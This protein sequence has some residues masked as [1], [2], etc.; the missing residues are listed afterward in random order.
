[1]RTLKVL[2]YGDIDLNFMDGSAV[3]L[4]SMA[5]MLTQNQNI[6]VDL[7]IKAP[8][9]QK[10]LIEALDDIPN[11]HLIEPYAKK[12]HYPFIP[13]N[14]LDVESAVKIMDRLNQENAYHLIIIRGQNLTLELSK[15]SSLKEK[16]VPYITDF[17]HSENES[18]KEERK[19]LKYIYDEF[20]HIFLQ[21]KETKGAFQKLLKVDGQKV[22][23][24]SPMVPNVE[25]T[26][27]FQNKNNQLVYA[28]KFHEDWHTEE[29]IQAAINMEERQKDINF[30][31][32]GDK[33]QD[34]LR[35]KENVI[36]IR[37]Q[38]NELENIEWLGAVSRKRSQ[39]LIKASDI[40]IAWRSA[41]IDND[42]SV[43][44]SCKLLEYARIGKPAILRKTKMH[45]ELLGEDYPLYAN[46]PKEFEE[47]VLLAITDDAV[48]IESARQMFQAVHNYTYQ[49]A[50]HRLHD[51]LWSHQ[52]DKKKIVFAGHDLKFARMLISYFESKQEYEVRIDQWENHTKHDEGHSKKCIEWADIIFCEWGLGNAEWYSQNKKKNQKLIV[53]MHFQEKDLVYPRKFN[54]EN[55]DKI[56]VITAYM[57]EEFARIFGIP[58][59]KMI[60]IDNLVDTKELTIHK[61]KESS[62]NLGILGIL[63]A[64]KRL[65]LAIDVFEKLWEKDNRYKLFV[66][67]KLPQELPWL[68][69]RKKEKEYYD[70]LF[71]R[72]NS[73]PWRKNIIFDKHGSD[74]ADWFKKIGYLLS[75]SDYEGSHVA[76]SEAMASGTVPIIRNW[77]GAET[78][79]PE[80]FIQPTVEKMVEKIEQVVPTKDYRN[81]LKRF[82][83][84]KFSKEEICEEIET[85]IETLY[86]I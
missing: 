17:R 9:K 82:A 26:P 16:T 13:S 70:Q 27:Q 74:I 32:I 60:Y 49:A 37:K 73:A 8:R 7:L 86:K 28:G 18:T 65:D 76:V 45:V 68:M 53:R 67:G 42:E 15:I 31:I 43:E 64:R 57:Y 21:T 55:I 75:T 24:L 72:I 23:L 33:F 5:Q 22:V 50:Y 2:L 39:E 71:N 62:L 48:Y 56:I 10:Y 1:M 84:H 47:K 66:K 46:T 59:H 29:I 38:L 41:Y 30:L 85:L 63:P 12:E 54:L 20:Q 11:L 61:T 51:F 3:W 40:G 52:K 69:G 80:E 34:R 4:I 44:L 25:E 79:Y 35:E 78:I 6:K 58:R 77:K 19:N 83:D 14:R 36:R 81:S